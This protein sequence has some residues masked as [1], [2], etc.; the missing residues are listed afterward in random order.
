MQWL[1][2]AWN[3][4]LGVVAWLL[5]VGAFFLVGLPAAWWAVDQT[6]FLDVTWTCE[7]M[8]SQAEAQQYLEDEL[9]A[10]DMASVEHLDRGGNGKACEGTDFG[11]AAFA[12]DPEDSGEINLGDDGAG[13]IEL[14]G[15]DACHPAYPTECLDADSFDY[16]CAAGEGNGP[17]YVSGPIEVDWNVDDPD[18]FELDA[19][20]DGWA[21]D[22]G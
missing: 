12:D 13:G 9:K 22:W 7:N 15:D 20:G 5:A 4:W 10:G 3:S 2:R 11:S 6:G 1:K 8:D 14:G 18:P 21:C 19:D 16:D 17:D